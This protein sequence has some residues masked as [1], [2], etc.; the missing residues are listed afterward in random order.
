[1]DIKIYEAHLKAVADSIAAI[2]AAVKFLDAESLA[3]ELEDIQ[4]DIETLHEEIDD[5]V[6]AY[7]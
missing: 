3:D 6:E 4:G 1:M 5:T 7:N 2:R